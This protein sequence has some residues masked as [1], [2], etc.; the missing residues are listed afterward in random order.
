M[1]ERDCSDT[2][3]LYTDGEWEDEEC[4]SGTCVRKIPVFVTA[5]ECERTHLSVDVTIYYKDKEGNIREDDRTWEY[6]LHNEGSVEK[7][8]TTVVFAGE[9]ITDVKPKAYRCTCYE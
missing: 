8:E 7:N 9:T 2:A 1:T 3:N 4:E 5:E 6:N